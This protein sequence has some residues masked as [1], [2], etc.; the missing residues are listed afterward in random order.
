MIEKMSTAEYKAEWLDK[1]HTDEFKLLVAS[2]VGN[3]VEEQLPGYTLVGSILKR[4]N[5]YEEDWYLYHMI[6]RKKD[7][8]EW[9]YFSAVNISTGSINHGHYG[10]T[11]DEA[12][13]WLDVMGRQEEYTPSATAGDYSPSCPWNAPGMSVSDFI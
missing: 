4:K 10:L 2:I 6:L 1:E 12:L 3:A 9:A 8:D 13:E 5:S 11:Y 7:S